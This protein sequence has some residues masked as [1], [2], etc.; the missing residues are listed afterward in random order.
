MV[1]AAWRAIDDVDRI[2]VAVDAKRGFG[3]EPRMILERVVA[4]GRQADVVVSKI[5]LVTRAELLPLI[6]TFRNEKA[7]DRVFLVSARKGEGVDDLRRHLAEAMPV[8]P[9]HFA[10]DDLMDIQERLFAAEITREQIFLQLRQELPYACAVETTSWTERDDGSVRIEQTIHVE[11][12]GQRRIVI[13][14]KG[15]QLKAIGSAARRAIGEALGR[16]AHLLLHVK[17]SAWGEQR[18]LY[19]AWGLDYDAS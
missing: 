6:G 8:G 7:I 17:A 1:D 4:Q 3:D 14:A 5:D 10:E 11:R 12:D 18:D 19:R 9:W 16:P 2:L 13:G 15:A